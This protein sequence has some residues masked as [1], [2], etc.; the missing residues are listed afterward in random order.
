MTD[1]KPNCVLLKAYFYFFNADCVCCFASQRGVFRGL[2]GEGEEDGED[3]R[4]EVCEEETEDGS[5]PGEWDRCVEEVIIDIL[6]SN[7]FLELI[8]HFLT[9]K[10]VYTI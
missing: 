5:E 8:L 1:R 6:L 2:H 9:L 3:V 10:N 4:H 7:L